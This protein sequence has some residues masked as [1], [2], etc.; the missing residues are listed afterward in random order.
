MILMLLFFALGC[1]VTKESYSGF[2]SLLYGYELIFV[3]FINLKIEANGQW[4]FEASL[5]QKIDGE[6]NDM[7]NLSP[8]LENMPLIAWFKE[9]EDPNKTRPSS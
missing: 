4:L 8:R 5:I 2:F 3:I 9:K 6:R 7:A 1:R